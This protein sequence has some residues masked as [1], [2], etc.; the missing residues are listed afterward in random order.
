[1]PTVGIPAVGFCNWKLDLFLRY[2]ILKK[3]GKVMLIMDI[4]AHIDR[5]KYSGIST[6]IRSDIVVLIEKQRQHI[7]DRRGQE[8]F[9]KYYPLFRE[10]AEAPDYI[11]SDNQHKNT[12]IVCKSFV[13]DHAHVHLVIRLAV[14]GDK[15]EY[16]NSIITAIFENDKRYEQRLRN[17]IPL[18]KKE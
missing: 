13:L 8:F 2:G 12:A 15:E 16:E 17:N 11:F 5:E 6:E 7:I 4:I 9:E 10:I 3:T 14:A 1:M 18:Y